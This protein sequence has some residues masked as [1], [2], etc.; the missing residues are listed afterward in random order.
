MEDNTCNRQVA[1][2]PIDDDDDSINIPD[3]DDDLYT[4]L[5]PE[6]ADE[7]QLVEFFDS[8]SFLFLPE[9]GEC[10]NEEEEEEEEEQWIEGSRGQ[11]GEEER[12]RQSNNKEH[13]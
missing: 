1:V 12:K 11:F 3:I 9:G 5:S 7:D 8:L 6:E 2:I 4:P 10:R 13:D